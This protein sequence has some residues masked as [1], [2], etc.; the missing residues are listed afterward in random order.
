MIPFCV[1]PQRL[2]AHQDCFVPSIAFVEVMF[3]HVCRSCLCLG[4][5]EVRRWL[6]VIALVFHC[7]IMSRFCSRRFCHFGWHASFQFSRHCWRLPT[8]RLELWRCICIPRGHP[9]HQCSPH[10][11]M[12]L[13]LVDL[14]VS[15]RVAVHLLVDLL[16]SR[17]SLPCLRWLLDFPSSETEQ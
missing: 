12:V 11:V 15:H 5:V 13:L 2:Q 4:V 3:K 14:L 8:A 1:Y 9:F 7:E 16:V 10:P 17:V 6:A